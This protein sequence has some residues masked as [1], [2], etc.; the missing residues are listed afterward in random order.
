MEKLDK[1]IRALECC[2]DSFDACP[3]C[4]LNNYEGCRDQLNADALDVIR[5]LKTRLDGAKHGRLNLAR[6]YQELKDKLE[7]A[8]LTL[9]VTRQNLGNSREECNR[10]ED[11]LSDRRKDIETL[12]R[13]NEDWRSEV[14][15]LH[16]RIAEAHGMRA[17]LS[18]VEE[19]CAKPGTNY[20]RIAKMGPWALADWI[21]RTGSVCEC[22]DL[23]FNC[24][25]PEEDV[26]EEYCLE[27]ILRWLAQEVGPG[28]LR[29]GY[30]P[31]CDKDI[32]VRSNDSMGHC[33]D[34][35]HDV[36]LHIEGETDV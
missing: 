36:V 5:E 3:D 26:T 35:G 34:C 17:K 14:A 29:T 27:H 1:V 24:G 21:F 7:Q 16:E 19:S 12:N 10:L 32:K 31:L 28:E 2:L 4:Y 13:I 18:G 22:C 30:C 23:H 20:Q 8:E 15:Q 11:E 33:P 9:E 6:M 25:R